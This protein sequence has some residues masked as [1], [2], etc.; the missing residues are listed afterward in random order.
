MAKALSIAGGGLAGLA[1]ALAVVRAGGRAEVLERRR[2]I[3]ARFHGDS[4]GRENWTAEGDVLDDL[5]AMGVETDFE[6]TPFRECVFFDPAPAFG[7]QCRRAAGR[8]GGRD[9]GTGAGSAAVDV[10]ARRS[11]CRYGRA[12]AQTVGSATLV[13]LVGLGCSSGPAVVLGSG[14]VL[15][16]QKAGHPADGGRDTTERPAPRT[17]LGFVRASGS[18]SAPAAARDLA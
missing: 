3:G 17:G 12:R 15:H 5:A 2:K 6:H 4:Q 14:R 16:C 7:H 1:A 10:V 11:G 18:D 9:A 8:T 13:A